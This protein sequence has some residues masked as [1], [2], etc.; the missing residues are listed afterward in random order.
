MIEDLIARVFCARN[1]A[2]IE[3][4][5]SKSYSQHQA[6]GDF[7]DDV[8]GIID[9]LVETHQGAFG[10]IGEVKYKEPDKKEIVS[11]LKSE[12]VWISKNRSKIAQDVT[13]LENII[14][15]LTGLFLTT[16]YKLENLK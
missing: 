13:A 4:W 5:K 6:L 9:K 10:I 2:H 7:Y 3:H 1:C 11:Y 8:I 14:D 12:L 15:E 16:V